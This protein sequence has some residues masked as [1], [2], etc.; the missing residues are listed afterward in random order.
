MHVIPLE[1]LT[2]QTI[3]KTFWDVNIDSFRSDIS[4]STTRFKWEIETIVT[5]ES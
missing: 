3:E 4:D 2:S 5:K 1:W